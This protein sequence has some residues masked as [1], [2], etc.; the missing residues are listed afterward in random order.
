MIVPI[1]TVEKGKKKS[2]GSAVVGS[3]EDGFHVEFYLRAG[4]V[5]RDDV[6][7][8]LVKKLKTLARN[9]KE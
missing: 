7:N 5:L 4:F 8:D 6:K 9:N 1:T 3:E 2:I